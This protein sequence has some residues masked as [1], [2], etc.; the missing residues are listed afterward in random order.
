MRG[1]RTADRAGGQRRNRQRKPQWKGVGASLALLA[2]LATP[3]PARALFHVAV[4]GEVMTSYDGDPNVQFVEILMLAIFQP[5]VTNSVLGAFDASGN[6]LGDV[7][8]V[9]NN[10]GRDGA[11]VPW[12]MGTAQFAAVSGLTPDFIMPAGLPTGGGMVCWGAPGLAPP[13]PESWDHTNPLNY[14][15]CLAYGSYSGP[16]NS[17]VGTPTALDADGHSLVRIGAT[18]DNA[19]DFACGDPATPTDNAGNSG[20]LVATTPCPE[21]G[22]LLLH[23]A[24][25]GALAVLARRRRRAAGR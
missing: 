7:L 22:A 6:Y 12:I 25:L 14:V 23:G 8:V 24:A 11:F 17:L 13:P 4:I 3:H 21:P 10:L 5:F 19:T 9:P 18:N 2:C 15:D 1:Y 20:S 16:S